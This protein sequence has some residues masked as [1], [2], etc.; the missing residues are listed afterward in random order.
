[1]TSEPGAPTPKSLILDANILVR[2]VL[3][4]RVLWLLET[5]LGRVTFLTPDI[6]YASASAH[7]P[8]IL[9]RRGLPTERIAELIQESLGR[10]PMLV[11]PVPNEV[12]IWNHRRGS[13]SRGATSLIGPSWP[14]PLS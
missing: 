13:V 3:G 7:L 12:R 9:T 10:L 6:A 5:Y 4:R 14:W 1:M 8:G 2:A 11:T